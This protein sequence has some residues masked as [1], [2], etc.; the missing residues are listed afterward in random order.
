MERY[1]MATV[2]TESLDVSGF[3]MVSGTPDQVRRR[4]ENSEADQVVAL[5]LEHGDE[6]TARIFADTVICIAPLVSAALALREQNSLETIVDA[7]VPRRPP[8]PHL[9]IEARMNGMARRAALESADWLTAAQV[10]EVAGFKSQN[11]SA[12]PNKWKKERRIFALRL[13]GSDYYPGYA[14]DPAT[15]YRPARGLQAVLEALGDG[16][17]DWSLA[18]WFASGN[19]FLGGK[20]PKDLLLSTPEQVLAAAEDEAAGVLHG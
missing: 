16:W 7:L 15:H 4:L 1:D 12:Q 20:M 10:A 8:P 2:A 18:I 5:T 3:D 14:L 11:P 9:L 13:S 19:S 17:D 6:K